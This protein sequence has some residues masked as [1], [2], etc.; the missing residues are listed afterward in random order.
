MGGNR[1]GEFRTYS[2]LLATFI[3]G[4]IWHGAGWTFIFWGFLHGMALV[5]HRAWSKLGFKLW[6]WFAWFITF[7]FINISW[8]FF[9]AREWEDAIKV[10]KTI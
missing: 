8:V 1:K 9:R 4:G 7:N 2:N 3:I 10:T 5:I 6:G